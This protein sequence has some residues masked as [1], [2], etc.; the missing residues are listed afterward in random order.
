MCTFIISNVL[1]N[2]FFSGR[3]LDRERAILLQQRKRENLSG[4]VDL[5]NDGIF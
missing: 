5:L 4:K 3:A 1:L 2:Y